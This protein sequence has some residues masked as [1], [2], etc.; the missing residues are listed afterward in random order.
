MYIYIC[1]HV[2]MYVCMHVCVCMYVCMYVKGR[3]HGT[4]QLGGFTSFTRT[5]KHAYIEP[6]DANQTYFH[7][8]SLPTSFGFRALLTSR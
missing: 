3:K 2:C 4:V 7:K 5:E 1:I 6:F 8:A